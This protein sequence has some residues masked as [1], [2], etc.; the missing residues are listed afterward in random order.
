MN[1]LTERFKKERSEHKSNTKSNSAEKATTAVTSE[2]SETAA[3][4]TDNKS[5]GGTKAADNKSD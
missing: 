4:R 1:D 2:T 5:A 3:A